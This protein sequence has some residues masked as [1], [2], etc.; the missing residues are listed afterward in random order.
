MKLIVGL[1]NPG[2]E[3]A[4]TRHN[5]GFEVVDALAASMDASFK[6]QKDFKAE[7]AEIR[8]GSEKVLLAKPVTF[9]NLSG[10]AVR[11]LASFFKLSVQDILIVHD[12]MDYAPGVF[13]FSTGS[14]PAGHN[15]IESVQEA[16]GT[17]E[18]ARLRIGVGRPT[19]EAKEDYVLG[20]PS[21]SDR[22]LI[23]GVIEDAGKAAQDWVSQGLT[24]AMNT[25]N[26]LKR[27]SS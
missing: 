15:G 12:E 19:V 1:G 27:A 13:A 20:R 14:G 7:I 11:A 4:D 8:I 5:L 26:G 17:K 25:W 24:K 21:A 23:N 10:D 16:V 18:I 3:Y 2:K 9:M 6:L 22:K